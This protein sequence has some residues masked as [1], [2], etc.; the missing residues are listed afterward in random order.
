MG[1]LTREEKESGIITVCIF[2]I[3]M[4]LLFVLKFDVDK[5]EEL[6][7]IVVE[8]LD[9]G[10]GGGGGVAINFGDSDNGLGAKFQ[11]DAVAQAAPSQSAPAEEVVG[12]DD[13]KAEAVANT[14]PVKNRDPKVQ[15]PK[16]AVDNTPKTPAPPRNAALDAIMGG[17]NTGSSGNTS[18]GGNQGANNGL[19]NGNYGTG[20]SGGGNGGGNGSGDGTGT[21]PGT[22]SGSGG[23]NGGGRGTGNGNY[24]LDGR[25]VLT[26][27]Q[28]NYTCN[29]Q[30]TVV[31]SISVDQNGKVISAS[32]GAKGTTNAARCLLDQ[33]KIAAMNTKFDASNSAPDKQVGTIVYK[34]TLTE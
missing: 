3:V 23:G 2:A 9:E 1:K 5:K 27:P 29:E 15:N 13:D 32:P 17:S 25:K 4:L 33:A 28:P 11:N 31:V 12:S 7:E 19:S 16:P 20:G 10:G 34:F 22:G 18:P 26:K 14:Q 24:R 21:G 8:V 6:K 30:G